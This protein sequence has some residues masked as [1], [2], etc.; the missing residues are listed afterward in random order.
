VIKRIAKKL[1]PKVRGAEAERL[2]KRGDNAWN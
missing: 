1:L 2:K